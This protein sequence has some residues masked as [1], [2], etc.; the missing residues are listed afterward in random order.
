MSK[1]DPDRFERM[2]EGIADPARTTW[3]YDNGDPMIDDAAAFLRSIAKPHA[4]KVYAT[5]MKIRTVS[6]SIPLTN[7]DFAKIVAVAGANNVSVA[8]W[9]RARLL[10]DCET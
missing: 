3:E 5:A 1:I 9:C 8:E 10:A 4:V 7:E 6:V 2:I